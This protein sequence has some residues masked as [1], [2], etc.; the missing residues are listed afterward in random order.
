MGRC[1]GS[2][3][4]A[5]VSFLRRVSVRGQTQTPTECVAVNREARGRHRAPFQWERALGVSMPRGTAAFP[6]ARVLRAAAD[7]LCPE[8]GGAQCSLAAPAGT[9]GKCTA[10]WH[11]RLHL[12]L[13]SQPEASQRLRS[14]AGECTSTVSPSGLALT[15]CPALF[16]RFPFHFTERRANTPVS[17]SAFWMAKKLQR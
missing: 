6:A 15:L 11:E 1:P 17:S 9:G 2:A 8:L 5:L 16:C 13:S 4:P 12:L 3:P 10:P 14:A 7:A